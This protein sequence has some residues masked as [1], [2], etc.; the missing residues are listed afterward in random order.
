LGG[1]QKCPLFSLGPLFSLPPKVHTEAIFILGGIC[2]PFLEI[3]AIFWAIFGHFLKKPPF[4]DLVESNSSLHY[5][6]EDFY[7]KQNVWEGFFVLP[8]CLADC[9]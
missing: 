9:R 3:L 8:I 7:L 4:F 2:Y 5:V 6:L 1:G